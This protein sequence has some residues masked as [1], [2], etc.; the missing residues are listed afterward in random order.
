MGHEGCQA[1][2]TERGNG[3]PS[4]R[5]ALRPINRRRPSRARSTW[6]SSIGS[7][8]TKRFRRTKPQAKR[9]MRPRAKRRREFSEATPSLP[10]VLWP[11][12]APVCGSESRSGARLRETADDDEGSCRRSRFHLCSHLFRN[13]GCFQGKIRQ[14]AEECC[15]DL[16]PSGPNKRLVLRKITF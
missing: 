12:R 13:R 4:S 15:L 5:P 3:R 16:C 1:S 9:T 8:C 7:N 2:W 6:H 10:S 11:L 14:S